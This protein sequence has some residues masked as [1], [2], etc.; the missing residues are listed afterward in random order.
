VDALPTQTTAGDIGGYLDHLKV[1]SRQDLPRRE[2]NGVAKVLIALFFA[3]FISLTARA[4]PLPSRDPRIIVPLLQTWHEHD[5]FSRL[6]LLLG[7]PDLDIGSSIHIWVFRLNDGT[8]IYANAAQ[9]DRMISISRS[10]PGGLAQKLYQ[11]IAHD[12]DRPQPSS[13]PF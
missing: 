6:T 11:P 9:R 12:L 13:A 3:L 1:G 8:S 5:G 2:A 4:N 10:A 7:Q